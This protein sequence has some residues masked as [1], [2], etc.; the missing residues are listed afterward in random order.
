ME[1]ENISSLQKHGNSESPV[2]TPFKL[3][4]YLTTKMTSGFIPQGATEKLKQI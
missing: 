3:Y 4:Q 1:Y 2:C